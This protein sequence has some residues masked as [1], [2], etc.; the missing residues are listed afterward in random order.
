MKAVRGSQRAHAAVR[1]HAAARVQVRERARG[2]GRAGVTARADGPRAPPEAAP[3]RWPGAAATRTRDRGAGQHLQLTGRRELTAPAGT[4]RQRGELKGPTGTERQ[5]PEGGWRGGRG[6]RGSPRPGAR[7]PGEPRGSGEHSAG[8][9]RRLDCPA[10]RCTRCRCQP[11]QVAAGRGRSRWYC[12]GPPG[13]RRS[14]PAAAPRDAMK[15]E[16]RSARCPTSGPGRYGKWSRPG[17]HEPSAASAP[18]DRA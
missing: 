8:S 9:A 12:R 14:L 15:C 18:R 11:G 1:T 10:A 17:T 2:A 7:G 3:A 4:E 6:P 13:P 16:S 5:R